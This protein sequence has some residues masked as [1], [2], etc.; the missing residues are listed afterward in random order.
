MWQW[1]PARPDDAAFMA[2][3][4]TANQRQAWGLDGAV[5]DP[6]LDGVLAQQHRWREAAY[7]D[8][9][10][11]AGCRLIVPQ[12]GGEPVGRAWVHAADTLHLL[13]LAVLPAQQR[14]GI[15]RWAL[16]A[17][18]DEATRLG[19]ALSLTVDANNPARALYQ[20]MGFEEHGDSGT[21]RHLHWAPR[22]PER[23]HEQA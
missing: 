15:G 20:R 23:E 14:Q 21:D 8:T 7:E 2:A 22:Q 16:Q 17:L 13:D 5:P 10:G 3:L 9:A 19:L 11:R 12:D 1:R 4:F 6:L 18:Q